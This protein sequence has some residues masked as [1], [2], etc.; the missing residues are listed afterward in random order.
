MPSSRPFAP[1]RIGLVSLLISVGLLTTIAVQSWALFDALHQSSTLVQAV[2]ERSR[3]ATVITDRLGDAVEEARNLFLGVAGGIY[4]PSGSVRKLTRLEQELAEGWANA[5][6]GAD[7]LV[8]PEVIAKAQQAMERLPST[9]QAAAV[10]FAASGAKPSAAD[11]QKLEA[12]HDE[13][14]DLRTPL[15][16]FVAGLRARIKERTEANINQSLDDSRVLNNRLTAV[17]AAAAG[18]GVLI[19]VFVYI[20]LTFTIAR[21]IACLAA[22]M[23][24]L[25]AGDL[26][27]AV[28]LRVRLREIAEMADAVQVF[29]RAAEENRAL[30]TEQAAQQARAEA[31]KTQALTTMADAIQDA[32]RQ[33]MARAAALSADLSREAEAMAESARL[34]S[35][36][37]ANVAG[38]AAQT[39]T[40]VDA[41]SSST[42]AM[43]AAIRDVAGQV[44]RS[45]TVTRQA[46]GAAKR[47]QDSITALSACVERIGAVTQ[48]IR[49]I[50]GQTNLLAL[51]A[52]IE[53]ARAGV[54]GKGFAVV[55]QE[56]KG[57]ANQ[58]S[59]STEEIAQQ[60]GE[61]ESRTGAAVATLRDMLAIIAEVETVATTVGS[62]V[63]R[64]DGTAESIGTIVTEIADSA[65]LVATR[66]EEVAVEAKATGERA[67]AVR[68]I[69]DRME[70]EIGD[71]S[72]QL[73]TAIATS[74]ALIDTS[75]THDS[76]V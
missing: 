19:A 70:T 54:A 9:F 12:F 50:A 11:R 26:A 66:I 61:I 52:T 45:G 33:A 53:A 46:L 29:R 37:S 35:G 7:G 48:M 17:G 47:T 73:A 6:A 31:A 59:R 4:S 3:Q 39:L 14:L 18:V 67:A 38:A 1:V 15:A 62:S 63:E 28:A 22:M 25:A 30:H 72:R 2:A 75:H 64:Q 8:A 44:D 74:M 20:V 16:K 27:I 23:K 36:N 24:R 40:T 76:L 65:H 51:N 69:A 21:P 5:R 57:L 10:L 32:L 42:A 49:G 58:A 71:L 56:V 13:W 68:V 34:V 55:A 41:V 43:R 60:I